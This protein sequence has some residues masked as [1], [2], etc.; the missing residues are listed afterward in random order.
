MSNLP[1]RDE[2]RNLLHEKTC[3][4]TF[5]KVNGEERIMNCTL[6]MDMVPEDQLPKGTGVVLNENTG[7]FRVFD[8]DKSAWRSF[9][10]ECVTQFAVEKK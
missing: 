5:T 9:K 1:T 6:N 4:V 3:Q 2:M 7:V 8:V 10:V